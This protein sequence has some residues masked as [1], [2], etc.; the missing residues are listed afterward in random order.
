MKLCL[1]VVP[2]LY[3]MVRSFSYLFKYLFS[4][5][6]N[7]KVW[8][9]LHGKFV[10][11]INA[12][13]ELG[14]P[15][16]HQVVEKG[17][18]LIMIGDNENALIKLREKILKKTKIIYYAIDLSSI[19]D[20]SFLEKYDIGLLINLLTMEDQ[21]PK[22]FINQKI[23]RTVD[24]HIRSQYQILKTVLTQMTEK[25]KGFI[26]TVNLSYSIHPYPQRAFVSALT[27]SFKL[28]SESMYYEMMSSNINIEFMDIGPLTYS[29][30]ASKA[31]IFR[32]TPQIV[33]KY[34]LKTLGASFFTIPYFPHML[35]YIGLFIFPGFIVAR[36]RHAKNEIRI[37]NYHTLN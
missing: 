36:Q 35:E 30:N 4:L 14:E 29:H 2:I 24:F 10:V 7:Y 34:I 28:W 13:T 31:N 9:S 26:V 21:N 1:L 33:A 32:P 37:R 5:L 19:S 23:S 3:C 27:S 17:L 16:C 6:N 11:V 25:H 20:F 8:E 22:Y 12:N 15:I 18:K